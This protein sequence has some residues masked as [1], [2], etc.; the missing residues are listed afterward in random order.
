MT[1][2]SWFASLHCPYQHPCS[3]L[4]KLYSRYIYPRRLVPSP[5]GSRSRVKVS[6]LETQVAISHPSQHHVGVWRELDLSSSTTAQ[7]ERALLPPAPNILMKMCEK[8]NSQPI[9]KRSMGVFTVVDFKTYHK[10]IVIKIVW[11]WYMDRHIDQWDRI[12][13]PE[14]N[15]YLK[16]LD[17]WQRQL[18]QGKNNIS[19]S[20]AGKLNIRKQNN[21]VRSLPHTIYE[22]NTKWIINLNVRSKAINFLEEKVFMILIWIMF[23]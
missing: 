1:L 5:S 17:F 13:S 3:V 15:S 2:E 16:S 18:S 11:S 7:R 20:S 12:Q 6:F 8:L 19:V 22:N 14:R 9:L 23:S 10:P 4:G 21:E